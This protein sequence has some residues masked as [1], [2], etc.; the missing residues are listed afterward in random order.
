M[1]GCPE[2]EAAPLGPYAFAAV[3]NSGAPMSGWSLVDQ[4]P[5]G[6]SFTS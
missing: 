2:R 6:R 3:L 1:C 4:S 5:S